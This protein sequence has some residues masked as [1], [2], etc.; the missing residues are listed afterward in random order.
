[1]KRKG[2]YK[3]GQIM[4]DYAP[5]RADILAGMHFQKI[6][7]KHVISLSSVYRIYHMFVEEKK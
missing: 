5:V 1:M 7:D 2:N 6:A 3:G 4:I